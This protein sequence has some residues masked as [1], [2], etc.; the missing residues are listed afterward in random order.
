MP[1]T[2]Q[3]SQVPE[4]LYAV[5]TTGAAAGAIAAGFWLIPA[6]GLRATTWSAVALNLAAAAGALWLLRL[7]RRVKPI[8][9]PAQPSKRVRLSS[10]AIES[11][12]ALALAAAALSGFCALVF[13]VTWTRL[14][15]LIIGP[16][17]YAFAVM[18]ASFII[19]IAAGSTLGVRLSRVS[20]RRVMWLCVSLMI[21]A[22]GTVVATW[23]TATRMPFIVAR[24]VSA[25]SAF[26]PLL[27][28][29][30][31]VLGLTL[32]AASAAFGVT[33]TLALAI[34]SSSPAS[35]ARDTARVYTA[36]TIGAVGGAIAAGFVL[37]P[38]FGLESTFLHTGRLLIAGGGALALFSGVRL[39]IPRRT[40]ILV[41][42]VAFAL[43]AGTFV[44]PAWN[45]S[46]L[47]GGLY[48]YARGLDADSLEAGL[49]AGRLEYYKEGAS[50]TVSV[51]TARRHA[52]AGDRRQS[53]CV[54]RRRHADAAASRTAAVLAHGNPRSALVIGLGSGVT[55]DAVAAIAKQSSILTSSK[56]R[57]RSFR[58]HRCSKKRTGKCSALRAFDYCRRWPHS[59]AADVA[60]L[61]RHRLGTV[62]SMDGRRG[63][64]VYPGVLSRPRATG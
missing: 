33:F 30:A 15:A 17:T 32:I 43:V 11:H 61:R 58:R 60:P 46:L 62:E 10:A 24:Y 63:C 50:G 47:A 34:A 18:A 21:A 9:A 56:S 5:N 13:E 16:T 12:A 26:G 54:E 1:T 53:R 22:A 28:R 44:L 4:R 48:K 27:L 39:W 8:A 31:A 64:V 45:R 40:A 52:L 2:A 59:L 38:L 6:Y 41:V 36:N 25:S 49:H 14:I 37:V 19:A 51:K 55:A 7:D 57:R 29:E 3:S 23:F 20:S 42:A 35:A